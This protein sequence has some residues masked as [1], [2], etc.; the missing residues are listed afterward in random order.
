MKIPSWLIF[1]LLALAGIG[2]I[3]QIGTNPSMFIIPIV[4]VV[5][6]FAA[7]KWGPKTSK[8]RVKKSARTE[9]K[10]KA[11]TQQHKQK[12]K[13]VKA[14]R[15]KSQAKLQVIEGHKGKS[16]AQSGE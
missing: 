2:L 4:L 1:A 16:R 3:S 9:A 7:Y 5:I 8:P 15:K 11:M 10:V 6:I 14:V 13:P 12:A